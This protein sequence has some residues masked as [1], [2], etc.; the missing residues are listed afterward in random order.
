MEQEGTSGAQ[1]VLGAPLQ[2]IS[3]DRFNQLRPWQSPSMPA[4]QDKKPESPS[5]HESELGVVTDIRSKIAFF[6]NNQHGSTNTNSFAIAASPTRSPIRS[7]FN[8][9]TKA[10]SRANS[11]FSAPSDP[12]DLMEMV[13]A[14]QA[15]LEQSRNRERLVAER[16][17]SLMEQLQNAHS[18]TR[19]EHKESE[20]EVKAMKKQVHKAELALI[21]CQQE[22]HEARNEQEAF[23][24]RAEHERQAKDK[25]RQEAFERA[26]TLASNLEELEVVKRE[27]DLLLSENQSLKA[28]QTMMEDLE[29]QKEIRPEIREV[30]VQVELQETPTS[31]QVQ[32]ESSC[33]RCTGLANSE[34]ALHNEV[35]E[36][37]KDE[38][39]WVRSQLKREQDLVHFMN[40]Q[41]QFKS[42]PCRMAETAG[43]RFVHDYVYDQRQQQLALL[44]GVKRKAEDELPLPRYIT[45]RESLEQKNRQ[46]EI[47]KSEVP[48]ETQ[49]P[50]VMQNQDCPTVAENTAEQETDLDDE[51]NGEF[52]EEP[53]V[54]ELTLRAMPLPS[55]EQQSEGVILEEA[56]AIPLPSPRSDD[57]E[58]TVSLEDMTQVMVEP[59]GSATSNHFAFSTSTSSRRP[60]EPETPVLRQSHSA[61]SVDTNDDLFD[62]RPPRYLPPRPST[63]IGVRTIASPIRM[64]PPSPN[65]HQSLT[66]ASSP[67]RSRT[68]QIP[69]KDSPLRNTITQRRSQSRPR[70]QSRPRSPTPG[71]ITDEPNSPATNTW[72]VTPK[73]KSDRQHHTYSQIELNPQLQALHVQS[74]SETTTTRVPLRDTEEGK[75]RTAKTISNH[76]HAQSLYIETNPRGRQPLHESDP[77]THSQSIML[78]GTPISREAA[79]AQIR[80][81]RDRARS[82]AMRKQVDEGSVPVKT[83]K[84]VARRG[85]MLSREAMGRDISN[86]SQASAPARF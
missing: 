16:V 11:T 32:P 58:P 83:P 84:S 13:H 2:Q 20:K 72:P 19:H 75:S 10:H 9:P 60:A 6:S 65:H 38:L 47:P 62:I 50:E 64:V 28:I 3:Q 36:E 74:Q 22:L 17:E 80:A 39:G 27:R 4:H 41:C 44:K 29:V 14:L 85:V 52:L 51:V 71:P 54:E 7:A 68:M 61:V 49:V 26:R 33:S 78:P 12:S 82:V 45:F 56:A 43:T 81:R 46:R 73:Q 70:E 15:Q 63:V 42:C 24:V 35:I 30:G 66:P 37:L 8:S 59:E 25:S 69:L 31:E 57:L 34:S 40:M 1:A 53:E 67:P 48:I 5:R 86:L 18:R 77:N 21:K 76:A 55:P 79:L 23:K